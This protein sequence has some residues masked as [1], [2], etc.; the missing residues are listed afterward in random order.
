M[1][2]LGSDASLA[3]DIDPH[4]ACIRSLRLRT[5]S[6]LRE[7]CL[8]YPAA[9][10]SEPDPFHVGTVIGRY[11]GRIARGHLQREGRMWSLARADGTPHC[12]HGGPEGFSA[13]IWQ[14]KE[15]VQDAEAYGSRLVLALRSPEGDQGFPGT[16]EAEIAFEILGGGVRSRASGFAYEVRATCDAAT[17]VNLTHHAYFNLDGDAHGSVLDH[18]LKLH[19]T[20]YTPV[21]AEG[22]PTGVVASVAGTPFDFRDWRRIGEVIVESVEDS[23]RGGRVLPFGLDQNVIID[24]KAGTLRPA[25][26]LRS[27]RTGVQMTVATT[28]PGMQVYSGGYLRTPFVPFGGICFETQNFPDASNQ[29]GFPDPW[30]L[31]GEVYHHRTEFRFG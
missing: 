29:P 7:L 14:I 24:G 11:A 16:L 12:L 19:A 31:P 6:G 1:F 21:D 3:L 5:A 23:G 30:V 13:R 10:R 17:V 25:A 27:Q 22:I 9:Q 15:Y 28:Q 4:G 18:E 8:A 26:A 20:C 2:S